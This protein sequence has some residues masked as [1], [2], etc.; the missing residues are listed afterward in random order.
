LNLF[1]TTLYQRRKRKLE[2]NERSNASILMGGPCDYHHHSCRLLKTDG[3][4]EMRECSVKLVSPSVLKR[5][6]RK[7]QETSVRKRSPNFLRLF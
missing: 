6:Y 2:L 5:S 7:S 3:C 1:P 4:M